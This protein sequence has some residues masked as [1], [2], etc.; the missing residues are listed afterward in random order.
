MRR[1]AIPFVA[2]VCACAPAPAPLPPVERLIVFDDNVIAFVPADST[3][4]ATASVD[5]RDAGRVLVRPH[6]FPPRLRNVPLRITAHVA[7]RPIPQDIQHVHDPWDRAGSVRLQPPSGPAV[8][9]LKFITAYG[10][11]T[12]H[13]ADVSWARPLLRGHVDFEATVD[14][15]SDPGWRLDFTLTLAPDPGAD[16]P[17][18][19]LPLFCED[20]ITRVAMD[21]GTIDCPVEIPQD[22]GRVEL[23]LFTSGHCTDGRGADEFETRDHVVTVDGR[24]VLRLRPWR[25]DCGRF[26]A[27]NP[28]CRRWSD[29]SWSSDYSRSGWCPGDQVAPLR[30][31]L[32]AA[33][34]PGPHALAYRIE[35]IRPAD[36]DG[37]YGYWRSSAVLI[38]WRR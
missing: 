15:W 2:L 9:L 38:G 8:E 28:Y 24:E 27:I 6:E 30:E 34:P 37:N 17:D 4:Y 10:G 5:T 25:D 12:E 36:A 33:L 18:W 26:R 11:A 3:R 1:L 13:T 7:T 29:G 23:L 20:A 22:V 31:D 14:T 19:A 32:S 35:G 16:D 21:A